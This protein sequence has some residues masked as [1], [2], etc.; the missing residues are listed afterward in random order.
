[1]GG[2]HNPAMTEVTLA[3]APCQPLRSSFRLAAILRTRVQSHVPWGG[4]LRRYPQR[5]AE[6]DEGRIARECSRPIAL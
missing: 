2:R 5:G 3:R 6:A 1:M 4:P